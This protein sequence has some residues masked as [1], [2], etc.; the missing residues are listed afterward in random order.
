M[1]AAAYKACVPGAF[2]S[3]M[4][5]SVLL[6]LSEL[7]PACVALGARYCRCAGAACTLVGA[8]EVPCRWQQRRL[9][10]GLLC[11]WAGT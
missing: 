5:C 6:V 11:L 4:A 8:K 7:L 3:H 10:L 1:E 2:P 9:G